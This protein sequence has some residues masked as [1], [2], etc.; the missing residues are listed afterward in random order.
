MKTIGL[1]GG[2]SWE[3]TLDY[4]R[5]INE[6]VKHKL[7]GLH[8][9]KIAMYSVDFEPIEQLQHSGDW[10]RTAK[11][12]IDAAKSVQAAG[13]D[14]LLICTNTMHKI[15]PEIE[16]QIDIPLLH[17]ADTTAEILIREGIKK[18]GLLGTAFTMEQQFY[19]GRLSSNYGLEVIVPNQQDRDI[20]H[21][22][23]YNELCL[24]KTVS[25][26]KEEYIRIIEN[27]SSQGAEAVILGCTEIGI[28]I[29]QSDT[30]V[31]LLDTTSIHACKAVEYALKD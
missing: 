23:I 18:V 16:K 29:K 21:K 5:N 26:S 6:E 27:L 25:T 20:V 10:E 19:K 17:I 7:G 11:I 31:K 24:G 15:A 9:A 4:Y 3:S 2:M 13:A 30:D 1:I 8:S 14:L 22:V 28:L 12:L